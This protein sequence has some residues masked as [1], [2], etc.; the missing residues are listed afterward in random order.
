MSHAHNP[1]SRAAPDD[2]LDLATGFIEGSGVVD[3]VFGCP[4]LPVGVH[5]RTEPRLGLAARH[6]VAGGEPGKRRFPIARDRDHRFEQPSSPGFVDEGRLHDGGTM[7]LALDPGDRFL[8]RSEDRRMGD[9]FQSFAGPGIGEDDLAEAFPV[10]RS[11]APND[12]VA[13]R[14]N[15]GVV[16]PSSRGR[17]FPRDP[18]GIED[19]D[20]LFAQH[21]GDRAFPR[22]DV[23]RQPEYP[24]AG[25]CITPEPTPERDVPTPKQNRDVLRTTPEEGQSSSISVGKTAPNLLEF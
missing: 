12:P 7:S 14:L 13:E 4:G 3:H 20:P 10:D 8:H 16:R 5:L 19:R 1:R 2:H 24:H 23:P 21:R 6:P 15:D 17:H 9:P 11:V 25:D 18:V 22:A